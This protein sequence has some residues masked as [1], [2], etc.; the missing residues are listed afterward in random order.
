MHVGDVG[1]GVGGNRRGGGCNR[2]ERWGDT[3]KGEKKR[4]VGGSRPGQVVAGLM[5]VMHVGWGGGVNR[6]ER[7]GDAG[8]GWSDARGG[9]AHDGRVADPH[10]PRQRG[11]GGGGGEPPF[12]EDVYEVGES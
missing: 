10:Q 11:E 1:W 12:R 5:H 2:R 7:W 6:R 9:R 8:G 3:G 4:K